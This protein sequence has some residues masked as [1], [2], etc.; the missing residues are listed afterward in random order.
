MRSMEVSIK[1]P[2]YV[3]IDLIGDVEKEVEE[4]QS[5]RQQD[6]D[7]NSSSSS[8]SSGSSS[9]CSSL[10]NRKGSRRGRGF[11]VLSDISERTE[12]NEAATTAPS[13]I[14]GQGEDERRNSINTL[15]DLAIQQS[16][17]GNDDLDFG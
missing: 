14:A 7:S 16:G 1:E 9:N 5:T 17:L 11:G 12:E 4:D 2:T 3:T 6:G 8:S 10:D 15:L 13:S